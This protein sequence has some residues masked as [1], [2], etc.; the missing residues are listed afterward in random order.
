M[1]LI[2]FSP[3][4]GEVKYEGVNE[5]LET[6]RSEKFLMISWLKK[7]FLKSVG[8]GL[9]DGYGDFTLSFIFYI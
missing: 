1:N 5:L 7:R 6:V 9:I 3:S 4:W 8:V 2:V